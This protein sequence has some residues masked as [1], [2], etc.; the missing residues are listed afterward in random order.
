[1]S[2]RAPDNER[3]VAV[4]DSYRLPEK[5]GWE[6]GWVGLEPTFQSKKS[7]KKWHE[8]SRTKEGEDAYFVDTYML[9]TQREVAR[10]VANR[11]AEKRKKG[12]KCAPFA[13]VKIEGELDQWKVRRQNIH[14][15][16]NADKLENFD[17]RF[18]LDPETFEWSIKPVPVAWFYDDRSSVSSR[19]SSGTSPW[20]TA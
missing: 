1:M 10:G 4:L 11:Y 9:R 13:R 5:T 16:W 3:M 12:K 19:S 14:F 17:A 6:H 18:G 15:Y 8:M 2:K 7:I 20:R